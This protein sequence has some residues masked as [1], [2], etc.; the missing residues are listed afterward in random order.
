MLRQKNGVGHKTLYFDHHLCH[1]AAA[2]FTSPFDPALIIT[3]DE[4]GDGESGMIAIGED[5]KIRV[6]RKISFP[7]S[8]AWVYSLVTGLIG[9]LPRQEE[10]KTQWLSLEGE[11]E[12]EAVFLDMLRKPHSPAPRLDYNFF[13]RGFAKRFTFSAKFYQK[14]GLLTDQRRVGE[15]Q[16]RTLASS[17]Q[18]ALST[19]RHLASVS[20]RR[21]VSKCVTRRLRRKELRHESVVCSSRARQ[22]R[23]RGG[24]CPPWMAP[25]FGRASHGTRLSCVLGAKVQRPAS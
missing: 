14:I 8:L 20:W 21:F 19:T 13:D 7:N 9:F 2:F 25:G 6:L 1:A 17:I 18:A 15:D 22:C 23:H 3:L 5:K 12:F 24:C 11:P 10:Q 16:R 4:D